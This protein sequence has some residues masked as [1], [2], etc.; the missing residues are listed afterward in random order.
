LLR[1]LKAGLFIFSTSSSHGA[2]IAQEIHAELLGGLR[3]IGDDIVILQRI[4]PTSSRNVR[5][6][7]HT[8]SIVTPSS[9]GS[10]PLKTA[11]TPVVFHTVKTV[12]GMEDRMIGLSR[13]TGASGKLR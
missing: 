3:F 13:L 2:G 4:Q 10:L 5:R 8:Q 6:S 11:R 7:P 1:I 12:V 9:Q